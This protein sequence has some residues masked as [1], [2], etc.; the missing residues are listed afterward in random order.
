M[1]GVV[2]RV[3]HFELDRPMARMTLNFNARR[4]EDRDEEC[5]GH[6]GVHP[7]IEEW[8]GE[9]QQRSRRDLA[10]ASRR[11][12]RAGRTAALQQGYR[13]LRFLAD[14]DPDAV[15]MQERQGE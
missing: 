15:R 12:H 6:S 7:E 3:G 4:V 14:R 11:P 13:S 5:E 9:F 10:R 2:L 1:T 8:D